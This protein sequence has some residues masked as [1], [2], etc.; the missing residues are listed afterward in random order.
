MK[1]MADPS[2]RRVTFAVC[3]CN[4]FSAKGIPPMLITLILSYLN[5]SRRF[6]WSPALSFED[7]SIYSTL[8]PGAQ[9]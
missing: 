8:I 6:S 3:R 9:Y 2:I 1:R 5:R 7:R 4:T